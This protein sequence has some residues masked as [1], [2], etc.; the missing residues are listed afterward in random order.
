MNNIRITIQLS[1]PLYEEIAKLAS[2]DDRPVASMVRV[3]IQ[4]AISER[5]K[6]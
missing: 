6:D 5:E 1:P 3:L 4:E 2:Q